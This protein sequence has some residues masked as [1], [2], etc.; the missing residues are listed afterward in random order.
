MWRTDLAHRRWRRPQR[1]LAPAATAAIVARA[2][3]PDGSATTA[4]CPA[5]HPRR[6]CLQD[7]GWPEA[8]DEPVDPPAVSWLAAMTEGRIR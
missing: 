7:C 6:P 5:G 2:D 3:A 8:E 1:Q 4:A